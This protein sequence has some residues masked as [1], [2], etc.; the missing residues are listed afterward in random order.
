VSRAYETKREGDVR[1][2]FAGDVLGADH[3]GSWYL[4]SKG[5]GESKDIDADSSIT[6]VLRDLW[7]SGIVMIFLE[8]S[9]A[10][11]PG[12]ADRYE[13]HIVSHYCAASA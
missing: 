13:V 12:E 11:Q 4:S 2:N 8:V 6:G 3:R 1:R 5:A 7:S 9:A 10:V